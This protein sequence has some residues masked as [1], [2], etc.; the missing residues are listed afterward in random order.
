MKDTAAT[1]AT[2]YEYKVIRKGTHKL[3]NGSKIITFE[4]LSGS[5][6]VAVTLI[7]DVDEAPGIVTMICGSYISQ[8]RDYEMHD[9][10][11]LAGAC[12]NAYVESVKL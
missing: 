4:A 2:T 5:W 10:D 8:H 11:S 12:I 1:T 9:L 7:I 3:A 6:E